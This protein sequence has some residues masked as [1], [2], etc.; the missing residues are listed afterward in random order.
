MLVGD[1][2]ATIN[3]IRKRYSHA[4]RHLP[5]VHRISLGL[6]NET[7][8]HEDTDEDGNARVHKAAT[9]N[10]KGDFFTKELDRAKYEHALNMIQMS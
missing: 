6:P 4:M 2:G 3:S 9:A 7:T 1:N 5:R 10:H 8:T